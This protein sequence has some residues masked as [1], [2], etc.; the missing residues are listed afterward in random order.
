MA[1]LNLKNL[2]DDLYAKLKERAKKEHRSVAQQVTHMLM[3]AL[4][5]E[6]TLSILDLEGLGKE[7]WA[8]IDTDEYLEQERASWD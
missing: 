2:P 8:G 5:E 7:L 4:R 1:V 6:R 3:E